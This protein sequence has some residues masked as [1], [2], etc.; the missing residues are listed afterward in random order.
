MFDGEQRGELFRV[1]GHEKRGH[2]G[3]TCLGDV[4]GGD[5][6]RVWEAADVALSHWLYQ[7]HEK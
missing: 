4:M 2:V 3:P 1:V 5:L 6:L 7:I